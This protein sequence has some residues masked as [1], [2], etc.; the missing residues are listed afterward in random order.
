[1]SYVQCVSVYSQ[2]IKVHSLEELTIKYREDIQQLQQ[3]NN[4]IMK[5]VPT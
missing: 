2:D 5:Y 4:S 1:M 3:A